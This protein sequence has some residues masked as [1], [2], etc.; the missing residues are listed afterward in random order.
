MAMTLA[1]R[2]F[3]WTALDSELW[4]SLTLAMLHF[5][6]LG[7]AIGLAAALL[8][9][10]LRD[11]SSQT[12]Y[13]VNLTALLAMAACLPVTLA[14]V[15]APKVSGT[16]T[17]PAETGETIA[18][19]QVP[20][21]PNESGVSHENPIAPTEPLLPDTVAPVEN[22]PFAQVGAPPPTVAPSPSLLERA[23]PFVA[24]AYLAGVLVMLG[25]LMLALRGGRRLRLAALPVADAELLA[26]LA[27]Q[28]KRIGLVVVPVIAWCEKVAVPV[29]VGVARPMILLPAALA[30]GLEGSQIEALLAHELAHLRRFD[31]FV[32]LVQ[33]LIEAVLFF[34]P[35]VWY[36]SRQVSIE[37]ENACDD[38]V[39]SIGWPRVQYADA[40]VRM[41]ELC[42]YPPGP[43]LA[44]R[45]ELLA[46]SGESP[47]QFK[48]R[49]LRL[50]GQEPPPALMLSRSGVFA[51]LLVVAI[52]LVGPIVLRS[53]VGAEPAK[54]MD[55]SQGDSIAAVVPAE[56]G[57]TQFGGSPLRNHATDADLPEAFDLAT[58]KNVRWT[59][60][61]GSMTVGSPVVAGGKVLVGTNNDSG[62]IARFPKAT[63]LACLQC[64]DLATGKF[65]W[66]YS[67]EKLPSGRVHDWPQIG[68]CSTPCVLGDR[69]WLVTNRCEVVCLDMDGFRDGENDGPVKDEPRGENE[70]DVI[71]RFDLMDKLGVRPFQQSASSVT[72]ADELVL[73]NTSNGVDES[74]TKVVAP[75]A[76]SFVA[77]HRGT[78]HLVWSD[79]T[80]GDDILPTCPASS[81]AVARLGGVWQA[82]F[83][84]GDGWLYG[85]DLQAIREGKSNLLWKFD[86]NPKRSR[87]QLGSRGDRNSLVAMPVV[88]EERVYISV[89]QSPEAGEGPGHLWCIDP[90]KRGD[91]SPELVFNRTDATKPIPHKRLQACVTEAGDFT[92][93]NGNSGVVWHFETFDQNGNGKYE[94][95]ETMH[96]VI[97]SVAIADDLAFV[98]D[99]A[100]ILHCLDARTGRVHWSHDLMASAWSTP[101]IC[102]GRVYVAD[103]DGDVAV[104][105]LDKKKQILAESNVDAPI[106]SSFAV[107]DETLVLASKVSLIAA[108][109]QADKKAAPDKGARAK[110][111]EGEWGPAVH[112][113]QARLVLTEAPRE[114]RTGEVLSLDLSLRNTTE[115][116][117]AIWL[118]N[119]L[120]WQWSQAEGKI[121]L[122]AGDK[123]V[124]RGDWHTSFELKPGETRLVPRKKPRVLIQSSDWKGQANAYNLPILTLAPAEY[125]VAATDVHV[126]KVA[127]D[128]G[129]EPM[130]LA[131]G[132][133]S[134][135]VLS[136]AGSRERVPA[137]ITESLVK[138]SWGEPVKGLQAGIAW[139]SDD[140]LSNG[141]SC[142]LFL[143]NASERELACNYIS[144]PYDSWFMFGSDRSGNVYPPGKRFLEGAFPTGSATLKPGEMKRFSTP[145]VSDRNGRPGP[146]PVE[147][148]IVGREGIAGF[149][150]AD[151]GLHFDLK[152]KTGTLDLRGRPKP[153]DEAF[154][155]PLPDEA[156]P[157]EEAPKEDPTTVPPLDGPAKVDA[158]AA[159]KKD[160]IAWGET[161]GGLQ[162]GLGF[163][164]GKSRFRMGQTL[165]FAV[166]AR[167]LTEKAIDL[168]YNS[169]SFWGVERTGDQ[170]ALSPMFIG[171]L[172]FTH[173]MTIKP[174]EEKEIPDFEQRPTQEVLLAPRDFKGEG[175]PMVTLEPETK[176]KLV[177]PAVLLVDPERD[178]DWRGK[179]ATGSLPFEVVAFDGTLRQ[180]DVS[181]WGKPIAWPAGS[182][183]A[184]PLPETVD[185]AEL[186]KRLAKRLLSRVEKEFSPYSFEERDGRIKIEYKTRPYH[187]WRP[188]G[189]IGGPPLRQTDFGPRE[190][191]LLIEMWL[192][193]E[194]GQAVRPQTLE[195]DPWRTFL[196]QVN[197][198]ELKT[199]LEINVS[200]GIRTDPMRVIRFVSP[201]DW[202]VAIDDTAAEA[203]KEADTLVAASVVD[204]ESGKPI[205][206]FRVIPGTPFTLIKGTDDP[207]PAVWQPHLLREAH[208]GKFEWPSERSYP[209]FRLRFEAEGYIPEITSW[210][211]KTGGAKDIV[212]KLRRDPGI[213]GRVLLPNGKPAAGAVIAICLPNRG[214]RLENGKLV[215][216]DDP[217]PE[218]LVDRWRRPIYVKSDE[219]GRYRLP[220]EPG[221]VMIYAVHDSGIAEVGYE[222]LKK[223]TDI[224]LAGWGA[225]D[226]RVLW[227]EKP[228]VEEK[229][230]IS[231]MREAG[232]YPEV[233]SLSLSLV[234]DKEGRFR[235]EKLPPWKLQISRS[236]ELPEKGGY[237][238]PH[239]HVD[240][241]VG[242]PTDVVFGGK[243]RAVIGKLTGLDSY[244]GITLS[245]AP[246][247]PRPGNKLGFEGLALVR[248]SNIGPIFFREKLPV[249]KDG[250]FRI[251]KVL[252][253]NYQLFIR[254]ADNSIY[255]VRQLLVPAPAGDK[256]D[257]PL[258]LG[259]LNYTRRPAEGG[260]AIPKKGVGNNSD[261]GLTGEIAVPQQA[262][263]AV[264]DKESPE[265][266]ALLRQPGCVFKQD[267]DGYV[268]TISIGG[269]VSDDWLAKIKSLPRLKELYISASKDVTE[270]GMAHLAEIKSLESLEFYSFHLPDPALAPLAGL[271]KLSELSV[272]EAKLTDAALPHIG[273]LMGLKKLRLKGNQ[274]TDA[275]MEYLKDLRRLEVL[276]IAHGNWVDSKMRITDAGV[277][278]V[279]AFTELRELD[280][281]GLPI[282]DDGLAKLSGLVELRTLNVGGTRISG[283]GLK[284]LEK[285]PKLE[286]LVLAGPSIDN[287]GMEHVGK[288]SRLEYLALTYTS[289]GDEGLRQLVGLKELKRLTLDSRVMTDAGLAHL[290][291]LT[292]LE[293]VELRASKTSDE[294]LKHLSNLTALSRIDLSGSGEPGVSIGRNYTGAG[295]A[296]L[297]KTMKLKTL[298]LNNADVHWT[299]L[300]DLKQLQELSMLMPTMSQADVR[301]LQKALP[302][303]F[304]SAAWGGGGVAPMQFFDK[305]GKF[306]GPP[307]RAK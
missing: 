46:A 165:S 271:P 251:D 191:G 23:A 194:P 166:Y 207:S 290:I 295:Y 154:G 263:S 6:W 53:F 160:A 211:N 130:P 237:P 142:E 183:R 265:T 43:S 302:D 112:G 11:G 113:V 122:H 224:Q 64:F 201:R 15:R 29:V 141:D 174:G 186:W 156:K 117:V 94:F 63:D 199:K 299:E 50:L 138:I 303:T 3:A 139:A 12:R 60:K 56:E 188:R 39:L 167:N 258:D 74:H 73:F 291:P 227:H 132:N 40:L 135:Q 189:K 71:W 87:W 120:E 273:A 203:K 235:V 198:P 109:K 129:S 234:S 105:K 172:P 169:P 151:G 143:R 195:S 182:W 81:P 59:A 212:V 88:Y 97:A 229:L 159:A 58:K 184:P 114:F 147:A 214:A 51:L 153:V 31:L 146:F 276:D 170:V 219:E 67:S 301:E 140:E 162:F 197:L 284:T 216:A 240:L 131:T 255:Q 296:H 32:N 289:V 176:A 306:I 30:S 268:L 136:E 93:A 256:P 54:E 79:A 223:S 116:P 208:D 226:G 274:I 10:L 286:S 118:R 145:H 104:F 178:T 241:A 260:A 48:R 9:R 78:G 259:E 126:L 148:G 42:A 218:K 101:M 102:R 144:P 99:V 298:Y 161:T 85:F 41:A 75:S 84:G 244:E 108:A 8:G 262:E 164:G 215:G 19:A 181:E 248:G 20:S 21:A 150:D 89:G 55:E 292:K 177:S 168:R 282:G 272:T 28:A 22:Q 25:R 187:A 231:A 264:K 61:L 228:G 106:Y 44:G 261:A 158:P 288:C 69:V 111:P 253:T 232:G 213:L 300:R 250:T 179:A 280:L 17:R 222:A 124:V 35:A 180:L 14:V 238:F 26:L 80:P 13:L 196:G 242:K 95:T 149:P 38:L 269:N 103:E 204:A 119:P 287:A 107:A 33:R 86:C 62:R 205:M 137:R 68:L 307:K 77:L 2:L 100:G 171:G 246:N 283:K 245:I 96:R 200:Y 110:P 4:V 277:A 47:S 91:I 72:V 209:Q 305:D 76:P 267:A 230:F 279:A 236:F 206:A 90:T 24:A 278:H 152:L 221:A 16:V 217:A 49:V 275:G 36:V 175:E 82:I 243:G 1:N 304:V 293:H 37:R 115:K 163:P 173:R 66:Q 65:L 121:A 220:T 254:N 285:F 157:K 5:L 155:F 294:G 247:A 92:R 18:L 257:E 83:A 297:A 252:P 27:R 185:K 52:S 192:A 45:A 57:W 225:I 249:N 123:P 127:A 266:M 134:I 193:D 34:H 281:S 190:D 128:K 98:P 202:L 233:C 7:C 210:I 125:Q 239:L 133:L 270:R 70:A